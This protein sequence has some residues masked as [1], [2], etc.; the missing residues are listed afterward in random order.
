MGGTRAW[1]A[2]VHWRHPYMGGIHAWEACLNEAG[3]QGT[4]AWGTRG[5]S[6]HAAV[7][8]SPVTHICSHCVHT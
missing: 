4:H 1:A 5:A 7:P 3:A 2:P 6:T 8:P